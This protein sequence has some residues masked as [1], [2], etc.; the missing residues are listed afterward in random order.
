VRE[1]ASPA[2]HHQL[3]KVSNTRH[4]RLPDCPLCHSSLTRGLFGTIGQ[5]RRR[6]MAVSKADPF[7]KTKKTS[8]EPVVIA[9]LSNPPQPLSC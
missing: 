7:E 3:A 2:D 9:M 6:S 4:Q 1:I 8:I 5:Q